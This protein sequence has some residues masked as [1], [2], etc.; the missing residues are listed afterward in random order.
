MAEISEFHTSKLIG[1][2]QWD[3]DFLAQ[4]TEADRIPI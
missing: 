1:L 2:R 3:R 4:P